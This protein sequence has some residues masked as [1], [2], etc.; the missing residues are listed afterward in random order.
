MAHPMASQWS[1]SLRTGNAPRIGELTIQALR[2]RVQG[3]RR[4]DSNLHTGS[5]LARSFFCRFALAFSDGIAQR[6]LRG[7]IR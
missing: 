5:C 6:G 1:V 3:S 2:L 7:L 4:S